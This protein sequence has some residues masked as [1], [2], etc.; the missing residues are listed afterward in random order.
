MPGRFNMA[1]ARFL[2]GGDLE[3]IVDCAVLLNRRS[4]RPP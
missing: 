1:R 2:T 4:E 3:T